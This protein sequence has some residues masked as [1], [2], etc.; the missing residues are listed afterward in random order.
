MTGLAAWR[1]AGIQQPLPGCQFEQLGGQLRG[2]VLHADPACGETRQSGDVAGLE[3][4]DAVAAEPAGLGG[5]VGGAQL[6]QVVIAAAQAP[7]DPQD[8]R[9]M[10]VVGRAD[11]L[12]MLG[13]VGF[14]GLL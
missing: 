13:P 11:G 7:V 3:Q 8:Q 5:D 12:P 14:Q 9:R 10:G 1:A 4:T 6:G 2:F